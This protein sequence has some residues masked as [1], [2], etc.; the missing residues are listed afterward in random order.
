MPER[1]LA[2][3]GKKFCPPVVDC[4]GNEEK[5]S[6][7]VKVTVKNPELC[8]RYCARVVKNV[9]IGTVPKMD[10]EMSGFQRNP[11]YQ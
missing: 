11:P 2:T 3:F 7:Y 4:K 9:K 5:A 6:D 1:R 8:P 10:A